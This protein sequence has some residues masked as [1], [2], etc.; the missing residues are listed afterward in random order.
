MSWTKRQFIK[1]A[2]GEIGLAAG[3]YDLQPSDFETG[4]ERLEAMMATWNARGIR[5]GYP[6]SSSP[7]D[8]SL[9]EVTGVPDA[10][11]EAV[12]LGLAVRLAPG[13][14]KITTKDTK[15]SAAEAYSNMMSKGMTRMQKRMPGG[16]PLGAGNKGWRQIGIFTRE[17]ADTLDAGGDGELEFE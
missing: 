7:A 12:L 15:Q 3:T 1:A 10:V 4:L 16:F 6:I 11:N 9:D 8:A 5:I 14:G 17:P 2:F 13:Y